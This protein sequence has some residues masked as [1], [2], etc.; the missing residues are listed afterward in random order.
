[1]RIMETIKTW[2]LIFFFLKVSIWELLINSNIN[3]NLHFQVFSLEI[4]LLIILALGQ[5][6]SP[7]IKLWFTVSK[8]QEQ[9]EAIFM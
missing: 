7:G 5:I 9:R 2:R 3:N 6:N 8:S 4:Y 1:M